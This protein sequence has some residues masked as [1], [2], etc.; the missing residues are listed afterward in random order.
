MTQPPP[1]RRLRTRLALLHAALTFACGLVL[2]AVMVLAL[3][4]GGDTSPAPDSIPSTVDR[5][6]S[7]LPVLLRYS[8]VALVVLAAVSVALGWV[9]AG[10]SL[11]P[12]RVI[13]H[14]ARTM[15]ASTLNHRLRVPA[16]Y[17]EFTE[18]AGTLD[19]LLQR[20]AESITAQ[21][22]F[23]ANAS[24]EL[25]TPLTVQR[26]LL[27]LTLAD[28]EATPETLRSACQELLVLGRQQE[29]LISALLTLANGYQGIEDWQRFDLAE[30]ARGVALAHHVQAEDRGVEIQAAL[31]PATVT[32]DERLVLSLVTNLVANAVRHNVAGGTVEIATTAPGRLVVANTGPVIPPSEVDRL[33]Q[34]FQRLGGDRT[35]QTEGHGLGLAIVAAIAHAHR[36]AVTAHPRP[37]GGLH[38]T[39]VFPSPGIAREPGSGRCPVTP[40]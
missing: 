14:S 26:T 4:D 10:R 18:L 7:N 40:E 16:V 17:Q 13:S 25:R 21:R 22:L 6:T 32:G 3:F 33:F 12:L 11:R 24:H 36:A 34:P 2:L 20:L 8:A 19:G 39:V 35:D 28:P 29:E 27:Q 9:I 15:S 23:V 37:A 5:H 38:V 30:V 1:R 31:D